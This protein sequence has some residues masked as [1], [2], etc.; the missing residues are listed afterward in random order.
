M[1]R[2]RESELP[3]R[4]LCFDLVAGLEAM[5]FRNDIGAFE[6]AGLRREDAGEV[7]VVLF[8]LCTPGLAV[9]LV[10]LFRLG[11]EGLD[12]LASGE[13]RLEVCK[14]SVL[15]L[16]MLLVIVLRSDRE[17]EKDPGAG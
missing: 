8:L 17:L 5:C 13:S 6:V 12:T 7:G 15:P 9:E 2:L 1:T 16:P 10:L 14:S 11:E 4:L 3:L